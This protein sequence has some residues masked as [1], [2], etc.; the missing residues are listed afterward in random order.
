MQTGLKKTHQTVQPDL[1]G[2]HTDKP[3]IPV[4]IKKDVKEFNIQIAN[5]Y[6]V[7]CGNFYIYC[8]VTEI[9]IFQ[10]ITGKTQYLLYPIYMYFSCCYVSVKLLSVLYP[11]GYST[12]IFMIFLNIKHHITF[13]YQIVLLNTINCIQEVF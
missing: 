13:L 11:L 10:C 8:S 6:D 2:Y 1:P 12:F 5:H 9:S 3:H 7:L 4:G